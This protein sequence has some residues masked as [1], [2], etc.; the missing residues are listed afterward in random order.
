MRTTDV[1]N[2]AVAV[3]FD[4]DLSNPNSQPL[5]L[6]TMTYN[7]A[8]DGRQTYTGKRSAEATLPTSGASRLTIPAVI[9]YDEMG[10][11]AG[12]IPSAAD[13]RL[14]G[15]LIYVAPGAL[16]EILLD[17]GVRTPTASFGD[18]GVIELSG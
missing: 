12:A 10:W 14:S 13:Y 18:A 1:T 5:E 8:V 11:A 2:E 16:A 7:L 15:E 4:Y 17:S 9:R 3:E 6:Q